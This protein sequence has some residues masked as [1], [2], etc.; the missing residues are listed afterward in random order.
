MSYYQNCTHCHKP[1]LE[2]QKCHGKGSGSG[3]FN[4]NQPCSY[5]SKGAVCRTHG[6]HWE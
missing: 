6:K 4:G 5:C 3:M 2:C 1:T